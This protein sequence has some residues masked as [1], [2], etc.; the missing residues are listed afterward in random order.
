[1]SYDR[2]AYKW[3]NKDGVK[4]RFKTPPDDTWSEGR[5]G[6]T[7]GKTQ[8][9][10]LFDTTDCV[11]AKMRYGTKEIALDKNGRNEAARICE[12][13]HGPR[14]AGLVCRHLCQNDSMAP[15]GFVCCNPNHIK[16][17][18]HA[19]N[20]R[21]VIRKGIHISQTC[22]PTHDVCSAG[23]KAITSKIQVCEHCGH[24]GKYPS[25]GWHIKKCST[26]SC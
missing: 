22:K 8:C 24:T 21:D 17:D 4:K 14:P 23:G 13:F 15:N 12:M 25:F 10:Y 1:M 19:E 3:Y 9:D 20:M 5:P 11:P 2:S 7:K 18:T 6:F 26:S 16:W